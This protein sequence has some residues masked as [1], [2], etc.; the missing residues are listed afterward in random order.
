MWRGEESVIQPVSQTTQPHT[1]DFYF[2]SSKE[3]C[4]QRRVSSACSDYGYSKLKGCSP[5]FGN[6]KFLYFG[7][8]LYQKIL[9]CDLLES[10]TRALVF[11]EMYHVSIF[12]I[13]YD[14]FSA[15]NMEKKKLE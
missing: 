4:Q 6:I 2:P 3:L 5:K 9:D 14:Y 10:V 12:H 13:S 7:F 8:H 1:Y 11:I 15:Q